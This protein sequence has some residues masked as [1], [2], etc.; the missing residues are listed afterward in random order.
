MR[1]GLVEVALLGIASGLVGVFVVQRQ[2][3]FYSHA[4]SHTIF[5]AVVVASA[6][7]IDLTLG[8]ALGA[9]LT[10]ALIFGLQRRTE[11]G[12][13][14]AVGVVFIALFALGVVLIGVL[15]VRSPEVGASLVGNVLGASGGDLILS[16]GLVATLAVLL[17][18]LFWPLV[19]SSFDPGAARGLGL[20]VALLDLVL[21]GMVAATAIL[22][23]RVAGVIL[24][25]A[26]IVAPA[27]A[28]LRWTR[29]M[30][31]AMLLAGFIG[32]GAGCAGLLVAYYAPV[33]PAAVM[34]LALVA[35]FAVSVALGPA[36][37]RRA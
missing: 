4:L 37:W 7:K 10:I 18:L 13:S 32:A 27:A 16:A 8:A 2:M 36:G 22:G 24:T 14:S 28:A 1:Y 5:P 21:L 9:A 30:R 35:V 12:H 31:P 26:L 34:V 11:V 17:R 19:L 23:V 3:T 25:T 6:F 20:P 29:R 15:R 33:A